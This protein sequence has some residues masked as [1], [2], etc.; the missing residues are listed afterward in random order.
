MRGRTGFLAVAATLAVYSDGVAEERGPYVRMDLAATA[1]PALT[2][3]GSDNDWSTKCDRII[4]PLAV[5]TGDE[6]NAAPPRT[7]WTSAFG[8]GGGFR[9]GL[10]LGYDWGA[11]R[12]EAEVFHRMTVYGDESDLD[13]FD[14]VTLDK[15]EQE[16]ELA[17][18]S[19]DDLRSHSVF[20]NLCYDYAP[21]SSAWIA[22]VGV[23]AGVERASLDYASIWKRNDDPDRIATFEDPLMRARLAGTTTIGDA[24]LTDAMVGYQVLA[25]VD[26]RL[27]G[28]VTL[29]AKVRWADFGTF[30]SDPTPWNQLRSHESSVG[31]GDVIRYRITTDDVRFRG[32]SLSLK[33]PF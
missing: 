12:I 23:G 25:G 1:A 33:T 17:V 18:G 30:E 9:A 16:I 14:D 13:V 27:R 8:G 29:G 7:S 10:A 11:V 5:E 19:V 2:V 4:N 28:P 15:R 20:V 6:C 24:R 22:Y 21:A 26:Y 3:R 32:L 31:R